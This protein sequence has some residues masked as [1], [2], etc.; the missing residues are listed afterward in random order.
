[1]IFMNNINFLTALNAQPINNALNQNLK[2]HMFNKEMIF[3]EIKF[4]ITKSKGLF[5]LAASCF[6]FSISY[7]SFHLLVF[8]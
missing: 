6:L 4:C 7:P 3:C 8:S 1:M 2:Q 5:L